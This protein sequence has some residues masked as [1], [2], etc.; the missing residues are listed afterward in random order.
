MRFGLVVVDPVRAFTDPVGVIGRLHGARQFNVIVDTVGRLAS[1]AAAHDGPK[2]WVRALYEPG[3]FTSGDLH[4]PLAQLCADPLGADCE[5]NPRLVPPAD[6][7]VI[8]KTTVD[9]GSCPAFVQA[10]EAMVGDVDALLVTGFSLTTCVAATATSCAERLGGRLPVVVPLS[11]T[12]ARAGLYDPNDGHPAE[13]N[14][15]LARLR[16]AGVVVCDSPGT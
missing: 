4:A 3:Q 9:A 11:L 6:A 5:W 16:A 10:T 13:V 14:A 1:F 12:A 8:T 2:L 7:L 15:A